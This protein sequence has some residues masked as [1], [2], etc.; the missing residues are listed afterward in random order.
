MANFMNENCET[1]WNRTPDELEKYF[2]CN[3][4][5]IES[6]S[7]FQTIAAQKRKFYEE[8]GIIEEVK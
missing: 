8:E 2:F 6:K 1:S 3:I 7:H 5:K 4:L